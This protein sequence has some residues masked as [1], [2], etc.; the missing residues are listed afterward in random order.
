MTKESIPDTNS[1]KIDNFGIKIIIKCSLINSIMFTKTRSACALFEY[2]GSIMVAG[3]HLQTM[4]CYRF[5]I[6]F[7][8]APLLPY[9]PDRVHVFLSVL[10][11]RY[12]STLYS[13]IIF[14]ILYSDLLNG[15]S[16]SLRWWWFLKMMYAVIF[17]FKKDFCAYICL[18]EKV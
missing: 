7:S 10:L 17:I 18:Y 9:P 16:W 5:Q 15:A 13:E 1:K 8:L 4:L 6:C 14:E 12:A 11:F 3:L 2:R